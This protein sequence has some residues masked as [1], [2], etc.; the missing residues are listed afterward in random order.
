MVKTV[1]T[2][3]NA[4]I[5]AGSLRRLI[6]IICTLLL[7]IL[8]ALDRIVLFPNWELQFDGKGS[9]F[10]GVH[11]VTFISTNKRLLKMD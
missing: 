11:S 2:E 1:I 5:S 9:T 3:A 4:N 8:A 10:K 7:L 6:C